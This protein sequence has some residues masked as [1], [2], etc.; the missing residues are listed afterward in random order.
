MSLQFVIGGAGSGKTRFLYETA[1]KEAEEHPERFCLFI[2]PEQY[3]MQTQKELV[4]LKEG[5]ALMNIDIL[6]FKRLAYRV[7]EDLGVSLPPVLD[8]MGKS[9]VLRKTAGKLKGQLK[10]YG[11]HLD[12]TGFI[13][14]L[15]SQIS[16]LCQYGLSPEDVSRVGQG[17][18]HLLLKQ[19]LEDLSVIYR[20]FQDYIRSHYI[21]A[22][23][24][25]DILCRVLPDW[26]VLKDSLIFLDGFTGFTPVQYRLAEILMVHS[27]EVICSVTADPREDVYRE[28]SIQH[29]FY[30]GRHTISRLQTLAEKNGVSRKKDRICA[31][32]PGIRFRQS[33][34]LS[35]LEQNLYRYKG[36][37]RSGQPE[38]I[39]LFQGETPKEE[40]AWVCSRICELVQEKGLRYRETAVIMGDP[41]TYRREVMHQFREARIPV[42][43]DDKK[44]ILEN[45]MVELIRACLEA[46]RDGSYESMFRYLKTG[47]VY[48]DQ[49]GRDQIDLLTD[50]LE[51]YVR[52]LGIRGWKAWDSVWEREMR[53]AERLNLAELNAFREWIIAPLKRIRSAFSEEG[54]TISSVSAALRAFLEEMKLEEKLQEWKEFF[55]ERGRDGDENLARE[56]GQVYEKVLE[57]LTRLE[58]LLGEEPAD[59]KNYI[60]IL[61]AGFGE[62]RVGVI[63]AAAD[64]VT[65]GDL[66]RTRLE[67]VRALFFLGVNEG[68]VPQRKAGGGIL[69]DADREIF[70]SF[71]ME[72]APTAREDGC[73]QKFYL[74]LML[75]KPSDQLTLT[76]AA[77]SGEGKSR[78]PSALIGELRHLFPQ[79]K[80]IS[81]DSAVIRTRKDAREG[82]IRKLRE[83]EKE[84]ELSAQLKELFVS[85]CRNE[86]EREQVRRL[87]E[88]AFYSYEEKGIG[89]AAARAL[90][91][92][93][94][95]GSVTRLEQY[96]SCAYAHFLKYGLE[97]MERQEYRL[98]AVDMGNLFHQSIDLC[99]ETMKRE[100]TDWKTLTDETRKELVARCVSQVAQQYGNTILSSSAR[101]A[102][103]ARRVER[104]TDRTIWAL[105]EQIKKGDF[106]PSGFEVSFTAADNLSAMRIR[107]SEEEELRLK[108]RIDRIDRCQD[109]DQVYIKIIDYKSG[110]TVFDLA[111]LYYGLQLQLVVYLDAAMEMEERRSPG[112]EVIPGGIFYYHIKDPMVVREQNQTVEEIEA[113]ILKQLKMNG[114]VNGNLD[115]VRHI[116]REIK[117]ESDVI[118][119]V[120]KDGIIQEAKS[121]VTGTGGFERLRKFVKAHLKESGQEILEGNI[122]LRP[123]RQGN[124]T[125]CDYCP[126]HAVCGFDTKTAGYGFR[127]LKSL[128]AEE[129]WGKL[130]E[131]EEHEVDERTAEGN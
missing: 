42:F 8:D 12:Q 48:D 91:G 129:V 95:Q 107:L 103:L 83:A 41:E 34:D 108:G 112:K 73:I 113:G 11:G 25:L 64:Q 92:P 16:E 89:R 33:P 77:R 63:P 94:L 100:E 106:V 98:E 19:K 36:Q 74:Y 124:R 24:I 52:A 37:S 18:E 15:K 105:A 20:G 70:R 88:A 58:G 126:Y 75:S 51:N 31:D 80:E 26:P 39:F 54:A 44:S 123:Y 30:M 17:T 116:D 14:Q 84:G 93:L 28:C 23:E 111:A 55:L 50:R 114:L 119:V 121:S 85:A 117:T 97:L 43:L 72:L 76:W 40:T 86:E 65:V 57:L 120:L 99:F 81:E 7:F 35:F 118:P 62:I 6:S 115:V 1:L 46:V 22:E 47:L 29:L 131:E 68:F 13:S 56:Y 96:A 130:E 71:Q 101:N 61:E 38:Q 82:L 59:M 67:D 69:T 2:V 110:S 78:R 122:A 45:P 27:R 49:I 32:V 5:H 3:T 128:K 90:Y 21:T 10:L 102:Y 4:R 66:T 125:A 104:I 127:R 79:L 9:M 109:G 60:Q 87:A 53:G